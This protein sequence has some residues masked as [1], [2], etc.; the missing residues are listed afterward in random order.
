MVQ[1]LTLEILDGVSLP[2]HRRGLLLCSWTLEARSAYV[3]SCVYNVEGIK[4]KFGPEHGVTAF[5]FLKGCD[6]IEMSTA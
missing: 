2:L 4:V 1:L 5:K 3:S 6:I